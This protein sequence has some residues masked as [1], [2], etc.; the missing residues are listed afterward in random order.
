MQ[1]KCGNRSVLIHHEDE[2]SAGGCIQHPNQANLKFNFKRGIGF[3][4][5]SVRYSLNVA[6]MLTRVNEV[7][8]FEF[9]LG[10]WCH[11]FNG[12]FTA[13]AFSDS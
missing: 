11:H 7:L 8:T 6:F 2:L 9:V 4:N 1:E 10:E 13:A 12:T 5:I 3:F